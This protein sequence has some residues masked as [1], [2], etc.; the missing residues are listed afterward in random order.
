MNAITL[1]EEI[2]VEEALSDLSNEEKAKR[3]LNLLIEVAPSF[4]KAGWEMIFEQMGVNSTIG[5]TDSISV[6]RLTYKNAAIRIIVDLAKKH[7]YRLAKDGNSIYVYN[8][9]FWIEVD[10]KIIYHFLGTITSK[11]GVPT[12][13]ASDY[14]FIGELYK[15]LEP[16]GFFEPME[17]KNVTLLNLQNGTLH[18]D[19]DG[20][21]MKPFNHQNFLTHQLDFT[22]DPYAE[23]ELWMA[24][25]N[26][27]LPD[28]DT[29]R[30]LQQSIGYLF[31]RDLKLEKAIFL[32]GTGSNG[33]SVIFEV[34]S[35]ILSP[36]MVTN[37]SLSSLTD[38]KGY[39][40]SGLQNKLINYGT[41]ITMKHMD[42]GMFKQLV[43]G[44]PV[45]VRQIYEKPFV[46]KQYAKLI[47]NLNKIDDADVESTIGFFRRM[48]F[49]PFEKTITPEQQDKN[50]HKK[51]LQD[52]AGVLNWI[53]EGVE[54]V[55]RNQEIYISPR[56]E[57]FL[58]NFRKDS[59][60]AIRFIEDHGIHPS[61]DNTVT[62]KAMY[63]AFID[64]CK[65]QGERALTQRHFNNE[66]KKLDFNFVRRNIGNVWY[67]NHS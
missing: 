5:I 52:K 17:H 50:L 11:L 51:I 9:E 65:E 66:L 41:D 15:Q 4:N 22:Y 46:M 21:R 31:T 57:A 35:G 32:Y 3:V 55:L 34:L 38:A 18:I 2:V 58:D 24:F 6:S 30:T 49:I 16:A 53:L 67:A 26:T 33:K 29:Q 39:H 59:N 54:E 27:V 37:Y 62:F 60:L 40:R 63:M 42:H 14:R 44:E 10:S 47:F 61:E 43:S 19:L 56:C 45:E 48:V 1:T 20:I 23:N 8:D 25:I 7:Q 12:W 36:Q 28:P 13:L 64:F